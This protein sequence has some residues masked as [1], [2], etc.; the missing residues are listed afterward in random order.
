[1]AKYAPLVLL[2]LGIDVVSLAVLTI[3]VFVAVTK[4]MKALE[5]Y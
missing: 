4:L 3:Y 1:M 5:R 2:F